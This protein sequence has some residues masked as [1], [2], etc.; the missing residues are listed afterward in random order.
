MVLAIGVLV[1]INLHRFATTPFSEE[2]INRIITIFVIADSLLSLVIPIMIERKSMYGKRY[3]VSISIVCLW[4]A[5]ILAIFDITQGE[6]HT[7]PTPFGDVSNLPTK[8]GIMVWLF[9]ISYLLNI[10]LTILSLDTIHFSKSKLDFNQNQPKKWGVTAL[11][12]K[13]SEDKKK[14]YFPIIV[15]ADEETRPWTILQRFVVSGLTF[16]PK[17]PNN[18]K[19]PANTGAIYFTFTRPASE[20]LEAL[21]REFEALKELK[22]DKANSEIIGDKEP[23]WKNVVFLDCYTLSG[24]K[25]HENKD[26]EKAT[27]LYYADSNDPHNLNRKY[28]DALNF[29]RETRNCVNIRV[30]YD[31]ISDF[32]TFTDFQLATQ[33]LRHNMGYEQRKNLES[34]YLFRQNTMEKEKEEYFL[35]FANGVM[36]MTRE[37][38]N[39][40]VDFR[41]PFKQPVTFFMDYDYKLVA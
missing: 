37:S 17:P 27:K 15:L 20:I 16:I 21:K 39:I 9:G 12:K 33:Y 28:E 32:L 41:G 29:L 6:P 13:M 25:S 23:D 1:L 18:D 40:R 35:W 34:L 2:G 26:L 31:A 3:H 11:D 38:Q 10:M 22:K 14:I 30:V 5:V 19:K 36:R 24:E 8:I 7:Y 4:A